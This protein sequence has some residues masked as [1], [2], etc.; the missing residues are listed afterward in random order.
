[1]RMC[2][3]SCRQLSEALAA[4]EAEAAELA[5]AVEHLEREVSS[6]EA[7]VRRTAFSSASMF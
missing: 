3:S 1:M 7:Q 5:Q 2:A 4:K 6:L